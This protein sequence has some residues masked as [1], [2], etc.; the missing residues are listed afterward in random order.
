M[1]VTK[2]GIDMIAGANAALVYKKMHPHASE[3]EVMSHVLA[4]S[5]NKQFKNSQMEIVV[6]ASYAMKMIARDSKI[7]DRVVI[8]QIMRELTTLMPAKE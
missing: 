5:K 3:E 7:S 6:G 4:F 2:R 1:D 8:D